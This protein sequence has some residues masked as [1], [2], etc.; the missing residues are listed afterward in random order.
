M[1]DDI[2]EFPTLNVHGGAID[3]YEMK[4]SPGMVVIIGSGRLA[5]MRL[6][7]PRSSSPT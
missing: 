7:H 1:S 6:D 2:P 3:G 4:L 5:Q